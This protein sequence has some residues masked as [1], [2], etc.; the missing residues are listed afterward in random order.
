VDGRDEEPVTVAEAARRVGVHPNTVRRLIHRGTLGALMVKGRHGDTWLVDAVELRRIVAGYAQT[1]PPPAA[2]AAPAVPPAP[3]ATAAA[4]SPPPA[5]PS[6]TAPPPDAVAEL[7]AAPAPLPATVD[8]S[9]ERAQALERYTRGLLTP[10]V[11]LLREREAALD[12]RDE[13]VREQAERIGRLE[14]EVELLRARLSRLAPDEA[15]A[16]T[17]ED[18]LPG[19]AVQDEALALSAQVARLRGDLRSLSAHLEEGA[20]VTTR[21][22]RL[23]EDLQPPPVAQPPAEAPPASTTAAS[24]APAPDP[25]AEAAAAIRHLQV[26][27]QARQ[28]PAPPA[29]PPP[30]AETGVAP[31]DAPAPAADAAPADAA[32]ADAAP[33][34][35]ADPPGAA[36]ATLAVAPPPAPTRRPWWRFWRR[37][38]PGG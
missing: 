34:P 9:L 14:R 29:A 30:A 6:S 16:G 5:A 32:P 2:P 31:P 13:V 15:Q 19:A 7:F 27:L 1:A 36:P 12:R 38:R 4:T 21:T 22:A 8:L 3:P 11:D 28:A 24:Q 18:V 37:R 35:A 23:A 26:A 17:E 20:G 33:A 10:L 25:F